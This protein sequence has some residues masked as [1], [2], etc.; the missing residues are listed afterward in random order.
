MTIA[1]VHTTSSTPLADPYAVSEA[2]WTAAEHADYDGISVGRCIDW[3]LDMRR[4]AASTTIERL[5]DEV[6]EDITELLAYT[7]SSDAEIEPYLEDA[8]LGAM[9]SVEAAYDAHLAC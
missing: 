5:I 4:T 8:V 7:G 3:M 1:P 9:A 2:Y 6:L